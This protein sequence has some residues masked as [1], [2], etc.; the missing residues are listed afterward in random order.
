M[1]RFTIQASQ[2]QFEYFEVE[3][4]CSGSGSGSG[5]FALGTVGTDNI[6][7]VVSGAG[8]GS[9]GLGLVATN[10]GC[11]VERFRGCEAREDVFD[12]LLAGLLYGS[13]LS[14]EED[15]T[16]RV[17]GVLFRVD[18]CLDNSIAIL[19][20]RSSLSASLTTLLG[21]CGGC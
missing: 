11:D 8:F 9:S 21:G 7:L 5:A 12:M 16:P 19:R 17:Y 20:S 18:S 4:S 14:K 2:I 1:S 10:G 15:P 6:G 3:V 13:S